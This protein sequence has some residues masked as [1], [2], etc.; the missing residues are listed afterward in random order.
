M[1][2]DTDANA[3]PNRSRTVSMPS[4]SKGH[5]A[6]VQA[7]R[8]NEGAATTANLAQTGFALFS[9]RVPEIISTATAGAVTLLLALVGNASG[10]P[11]KRAASR[12]S[13]S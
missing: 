11:G 7:G 2:D 4:G 1:A 12:R 3:K 5:C 9:V 10:R 13:L 8:N 6:S